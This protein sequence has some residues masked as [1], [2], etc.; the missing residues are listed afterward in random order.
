MS[1]LALITETGAVYWSAIVIALAL[2]A[3][4]LAMLGCRGLQ[5][6]A[7]WDMAVFLPLAAVLGFFGARLLHYHCFYRQYS[8]LAQA[9]TDFSVGSFCLPGA[10][11]GVLLAAILLWA[12][13]V[14]DSLGSFLDAAAP[15]GALGIAVGKLSAVF[16]SG[17]RGKVTV[18]GDSLLGLPWSTDMY[19]LTGMREYRTA[20]FFWEA[21]AAFAIFAVLVFFL[22]R[23]QA[24]PGRFRDGTV[25][26]LFLLL[27][28]LPEVLFDSMRYD[29]AFF[30]INGFVSVVQ[31]LSVLTLALETVVFSVRI[32]RRS[33]G[34]GV[35][36]LGSGLL[37][38]S[39]GIMGLAE[40]L[41]QRHGDRHLPCYLLMTGGILLALLYSLVLLLRAQRDAAPSVLA[42]DAGEAED[43]GL[44]EDPFLD[45]TAFEGGASVDFSA[46]DD[47]LG[48]DFSAEADE[49]GYVE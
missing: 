16:Y 37:L 13:G 43:I 46:L 48:A 21:L 12:F 38:L 8:S 27:W 7:P 42:P 30:R 19:P 9:L 23:M 6:K 10:I 33:G 3:A 28:A 39:V 20:V 45:V 4:S 11:A 41:V 26:W 22:L 15:G 5:G 14:V 2:A 49:L 1:Q 44:P 36:F 47:E 17:N 29:S 32:G 31:I 34:R 18:T 35:Y 25:L 24:R 40:Y